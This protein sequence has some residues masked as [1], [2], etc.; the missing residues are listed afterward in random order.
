MKVNVEELNSVKRQLTVEVPAAEVD[1]TID[2][3]LNKHGRN[4]KIKGFR[5]GKVPRKVIERYY[6]P[7]AAYESA[8]VLIREQYDKAMDES[9]MSPLAQPE[10]DFQAVPVRGEDFIFQVIFDV[11]PEFDIDPEAYKG[12]EVKE[13]ELEASDEEIDKRVDMMRDR[14]AM[15]KTVEESRPA[16]TG[17]VVVVDYQT[18]DGDEPLEGGTA[19]NVDVELGAGQGAGRNRSGPWSRPSR[20][21]LLRPSFHMDEN[22]PQ[23]GD[24]RQG[25]Q[26]QTGGQ[27]NSNRNCCPM[28]MMISPAAFRRS[29][30][31]SAPSRTRSRKSWSA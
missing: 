23:R 7:Q 14:Q 2:K 26:I 19:D 31:P 16:Q 27:G 22:A 21:I 8:E 13:P 29:S 5:P 28:L 30:R 10:F 25:H 15:L 1:K 18:F 24:A 9:G 20:A 17:D 6:G 3:L 4:A 11:R 12:F